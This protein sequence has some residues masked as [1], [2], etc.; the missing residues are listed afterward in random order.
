MAETRENWDDLRFVLAVAGTGSVS[1]AARTLGVNHAT[2]LRRIAAFEA[3]I[4]T[5]IFDKTAKGY[6]VPPD[7]MRIID[8]T[9]EVDAAV[10]AVGRMIAGARAP[11]SGEVRVTTTDTIATFLLPAVIEELEAKAPAL[12]LEVIGSN[13]P[14][15]LGRGQA[16]IS[17]RPAMTLP[18]ELDGVEVAR[19]GFG[20]YACEGGNAETWLGLSGRLAQSVPGRWMAEHVAP[21]RVGPS[22]DSFLIL[23][24]LA[25]RGQ[26]L[27]I[28][29]HLVGQGEARLRHLPQR[30]P[31]VTVPVCVACYSDL[32][33]V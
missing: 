3:A 14:V 18:Q 7:R 8:A 30:M 22:A 24:E 4:G 11:V 13:S 21:R 31:P 32:D 33:A 26:G 5:E 19:M 27:A 25:A 6:A 16:D 20:V 1:G 9:R 12:R 17:I 10:Q 28:L 2:V 15:D 23:R 29:P